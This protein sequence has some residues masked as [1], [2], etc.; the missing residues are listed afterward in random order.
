MSIPLTSKD[1]PGIVR[2]TFF[3]GKPGL[4]AYPMDPPTYT[5]VADELTEVAL[6]PKVAVVRGFDVHLDWLINCAFVVK[7][8]RI[9]T[10][11]IV[12][13]ITH[14]FW[15]MITMAT[16]RYTSVMTNV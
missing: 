5:E 2:S 11:E 15:H 4:I 16:P 1:A 10:I 9:A 14:R 12:L 7:A 8:I 6:G 13:F 3:V